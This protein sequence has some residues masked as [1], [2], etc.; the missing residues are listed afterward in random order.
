MS[1]NIF[2][3]GL[4][5]LVVGA[6][7]L[8]EAATLT[9]RVKLANGA[10]EP[11]TIPMAADPICQ[12]QHA[13]PAHSEE[14]VLNADGTLRWAFVYIKE[15]LS[16]PAAP[17]AT[18]P[19]TL[20]Q[21]GCLYTPHVFGLRTHQPLEILNSDQTLHNINAQPKTNRP[22]NIA[23]PVKG[24]KTTKQFDKPES[25]ISFKCNVHPW[26][27]AYGFVLDHSFFDV[28]GEDG[29]FTLAELPAGT[30]V[31]EAWH[32]KYGAKTQSLTISDG[33]TK[34]LEF[35]FP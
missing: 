6:G 7:G 18:T 16:G 12:Q 26:M 25:A 24:M 19:V 13:T 28:T 29:A 3:I 22:F 9:G 31:V 10:P 27:K 17:G 8:A 5:G 21:Q 20:N 30:Y 23:Q 15:G 1:L 4:I 33:E 14:V 2:R 32:E 34:E 35:T 11:A